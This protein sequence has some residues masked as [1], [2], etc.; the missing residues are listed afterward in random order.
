MYEYNPI[1]RTFNQVRAAILAATDTPRCRIRPDAMLES[2]VPLERRPLLWLELTRRGLKVPS[3]GTTPAQG[4]VCFGGFVALV[5][6]FAWGGW[7][8]LLLAIAPLVML[9]GVT[10][11]ALDVLLPRGR[12]TVG[13]LTVFCTSFPAH[14]ASGYRWTRGDIALKVRLIIAENLGVPLERITE[15]T[16][17]IED[18]AAD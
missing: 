6:L 10:T 8:A 2:L 7:P 4:C 11:A 18:L 3:L 15:K 14:K 1:V 17:F 12:W 16:S 9:L 5:W 13:D